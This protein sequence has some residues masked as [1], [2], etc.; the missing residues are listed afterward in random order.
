MRAGV[1]WGCSLSPGFGRFL[2]VP[3]GLR[4][5]QPS[6]VAAVTFAYK[7]SSGEVGEEK[8]A[9]SVGFSRRF[10]LCRLFYLPL[11]ALE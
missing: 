4:W 9:F 7:W 11:A 8:L 1:G 5:S 6:W 10:L 2:C 3:V